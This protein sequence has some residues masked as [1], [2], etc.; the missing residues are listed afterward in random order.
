MNKPAFIESMT[1]FEFSNGGSARFWHEIPAIN[2]SR[3]EFMDAIVEGF[4][5]ML[6]DVNTYTCD[7]IALIFMQFHPTITAVEVVDKQGNGIVLYAQWP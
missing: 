1:R 7:E 3:K 6:P 5:T 2:A 4:K